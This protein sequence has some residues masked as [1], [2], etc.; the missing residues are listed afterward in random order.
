MEH[1]YK[2]GSC[3]MRERYCKWL[4][5]S[6]H[7][8]CERA[9]RC[10]FGCAS[11]HRLLGELVKGPLVLDSSVRYLDRP[12]IH[13]ASCRNRILF[14]SGCCCCVCA[15]FKICV[16]VKDVLGWYTQYIGAPT[17]FFKPG[18]TEKVCVDSIRVSH[19]GEQRRRNQFR[20]TLIISVHLYLIL[21]SLVYKMSS[22]ALAAGLG[23]VAVPAGGVSTS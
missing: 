5:A 21:F 2:C 20:M 23:S 4:L 10:I 13:M 12:W 6:E 16:R 19:L 15:F 1:I 11:L 22:S 9:G 3:K 7:I 18:C 8:L 14:F 17:Q